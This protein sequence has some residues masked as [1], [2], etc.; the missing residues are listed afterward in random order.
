MAKDLDQPRRHHAFPDVGVQERGLTRPSIAGVGTTNLDAT[1]TAVALCLGTARTR[2]AA[3]LPDGNAEAA[4]AASRREPLAEITREL[5]EALTAVNL[6][7]DTGA[8]LFAESEPVLPAR[9]GSVIRKARARAEHATG[10]VHQLRHFLKIAS[11][12][13][14]APGEEAATT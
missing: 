6:Y 5:I 11:D 8:R 12:V 9:L 10:I 1:L 13:G 14:G 7:L 4:V 2:D 3:A